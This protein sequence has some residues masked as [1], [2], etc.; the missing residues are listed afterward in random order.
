[1][2]P[3]GPLRP[4]AAQVVMSGQSQTTK[5]LS[6]LNEVG[7]GGTRRASKTA[8]AGAATGGGGRDAG[9]GWPWPVWQVPERLGLRGRPGGGGR[10]VAVCHAAHAFLL[11]GGV[12]LAQ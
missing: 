2:T 1:M 10:G 6:R 12:E 4:A 8:A 11:G 3:P 9:R 7:A 5:S